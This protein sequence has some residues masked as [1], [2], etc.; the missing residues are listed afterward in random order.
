[1]PSTDANGD[2]NLLNSHTPRS[3]HYGALKPST[4]SLLESRDHMLR[5]P[6]RACSRSS[7]SSP[8]LD[9]VSVAQGP[10]KMRRSL[11]LMDGVHEHDELDPKG[12]I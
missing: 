2:F 10:G 9:D 12:Y 5:N 8:F 3:L 6:L 1:M 11:D 4:A 7:R